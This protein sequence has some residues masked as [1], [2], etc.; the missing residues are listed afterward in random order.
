MSDSENE[1][2]RRQI[3]N[4]EE[5]MAKVKQDLD[6]FKKETEDW[7]FQHMEDYEHEEKPCEEI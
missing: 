6:N 4:L 5:G 2:L 3:A 7:F 1:L